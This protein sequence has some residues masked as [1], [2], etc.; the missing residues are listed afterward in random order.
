METLHFEYPADGMVT[1]SAVVGC[2]GSG[3][4]EVLVQPNPLDKTRIQVRTA[5]DG[6]AQRWQ[7]LFERMFAVNLPPAVDI[8]IHDF[9]ATPGVVRLRLEQALEEVQ[10]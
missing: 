5:I 3:D 9:G 1:R 8:Q 6:S 7:N 2:V 4:L 10:S